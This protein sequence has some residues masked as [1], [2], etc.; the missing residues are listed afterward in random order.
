MEK[1]KS[2]EAR[3][4]EDRRGNQAQCEALELR[5]VRRGKLL[6]SSRVKEGT[7]WKTGG[8]RCGEEIAEI[9]E[10]GRSQ[11]GSRRPG[12]DMTARAGKTPLSFE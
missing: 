11:A 10:L 1:E 3:P 2:D 5:G 6:K 7:G 8:T 9:N 12:S 4:A